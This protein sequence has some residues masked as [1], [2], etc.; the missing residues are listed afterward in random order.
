MKYEGAQNSEKQNKTTTTLVPDATESL[1]MLCKLCEKKVLIN[2]PYCILHI[3]LTVLC[4][5]QK[6]KYN[7]RR[8]FFSLS[9][10]P[11]VNYNAATASLHLGYKKNLFVPLVLSLVGVVVGPVCGVRCR[12][13]GDALLVHPFGLRAHDEAEEVLVWYSGPSDR[14][15]GRGTALV[16]QTGPLALDEHIEEVVVRLGVVS[17]GHQVVE[18]G[19]V[20]VLMEPQAGQ[21]SPPCSCRR[22]L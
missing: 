16:V 8:G 1:L 20:A 5:V 15:R 14:R 6:E 12:W 21:A 3:M 19:L 4:F 22:L 17:V 13:Q 2:F 10:Q 7:E 18:H 9:D 11:A